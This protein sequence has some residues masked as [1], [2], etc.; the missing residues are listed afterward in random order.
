MVLVNSIRE[1]VYASESSKR[2]GALSLADRVNKSFADRVNKSFIDTKVLFLDRWVGIE[3]VMAVSS[4]SLRGWPLWKEAWGEKYSENRISL[5]D[6]KIII[7][8][9]RNTDFT[10]HHFVTLPGVVAF[11]YYPGS[12]VFLFGGLFFLGIFSALIEISV[13]RLGGKNLILCALLSQVVAYRLAHFGYVP[14]Q[15]YLLFGA[16]FLNLLLIYFANRL[17]STASNRRNNSGDMV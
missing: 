9:Y 11:F 1:N 5:Y 16:L 15:S 10:K 17:L 2:T 14:A 13:Y 3:G 8:P 7:S 12:Y 6:D 4:S